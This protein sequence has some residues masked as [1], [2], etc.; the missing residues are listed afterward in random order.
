MKIKQKLILSYL[1][2]ATFTALVG[3]VG[4]R[5]INVINQ[6]FQAV[7]EESIPNTSALKDL[8][9]AGAKIISATSE[10]ALISERTKSLPPNPEITAALIE[11]KE[12]VEEGFVKYDLALNRYTSAAANFSGDKKITVSPILTAG[13]ALKANSLKML[14]AQKANINATKFFELKEEFE[15]SE[16]EFLKAVN[17]ALKAEEVKLESV[18]NE[19]KTSIIDSGNIILITSIST[20]TL[21]GIVAL[22]LS[23]SIVRRLQ[24]LV[25]ATELISQGKLDV[26]LPSAQNDELGQLNQSFATMQNELK[27]NFDRLEDMVEERTE[28]LVIE[29]TN[30]QKKLTQEQLVLSIV[31]QIRQSLHITKTLNSVTANLRSVFACDRIAIFEFDDRSFG[32]FVTESLGQG[33]EPTANVAL[34]DFSREVKAFQSG[35]SHVA[36]KDPEPICSRLSIPIFN[37]SQLWGTLVA[38][39]YYQ[40]DRL[41]TESEIAIATAVCLQLGISIKQNILFTELQQSKEKA[42]AANVAKSEFLSMMS[43]EIRTPMNAVIGMT[44]LLTLTELDREQEG[45]VQMILSGGSALLNVIND[46]LDFSRIE[47]D[48]LELEVKPFGLRSFIDNTINLLSLQASQKNLGLFSVIDPLL[49]DAFWGDSNRIGQ[50]LINLI[51]NAIKF[52]EFGE[53]KVLVEMLEQDRDICKV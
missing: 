13:A 22:A 4:Y 15:E 40:P 43:H 46:I 39:D 5:C 20:F 42:E 48:H 10:Y 49:S 12:E 41:W 45:Y 14:E 50:I 31:E 3:I 18:K 7:S 32:T 52:T 28:L 33:H 2:I 16:E 11:E 29:Q 24:K 1:S 21:A 44:D 38:F 9:Y 23:G 27:S 17:I 51:G 35:L 25:V 47:A 36:V 34:Q 30:L 53:V 8:K 19:V 37:G 26:Q 6:D